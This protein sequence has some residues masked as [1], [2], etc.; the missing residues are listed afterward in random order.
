MNSQN[1]RK[2]VIN[3]PAVE[4]EL[5]TPLSDPGYGPVGIAKRRWHK[6]LPAIIADA[7]ANS[8]AVLVRLERGMYM[9]DLENKPRYQAVYSALCDHT[10]EQL[11]ALEAFSAIEWR[12]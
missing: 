5:V 3:D 6:P 2:S 12:E 11:K 7:I 8:R 10:R 4:A 9:P 1:S